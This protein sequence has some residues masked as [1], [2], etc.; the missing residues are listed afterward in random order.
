MPLQVLTLTLDGI[1]A[2]DYIDW[3]REPEPAALGRDLRE[4]TVRADDV[5]DRVEA[6]LSWD[7]RPPAEGLAAQLAGL[8]LT[9]EVRAV[10]AREPA[11]AAA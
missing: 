4:V 8:P 10:E 9:P 6:V 11:L 1:T 3:V 2:G 7:G 5:G